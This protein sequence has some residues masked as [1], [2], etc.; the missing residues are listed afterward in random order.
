[1][2]RR[3]FTLLEILLSL[4]I[5]A[6]VLVALNALLFGVAGGWGEGRDRRL[7]DQH[8][9]ALG[10]QLEE[11]VRAAAERPGGA[12][13]AI[14]KQAWAGRGEEL[15]PG[16]SLPDGGRLATWAGE[17]LPD[18][19]FLLEV[20]EDE[21]LVVAWRSRAEVEMESDGWH[22]AVVSPFVRR[23][24]YAYAPAGEG[25]RWEVSETPLPEPGFTGW[26]TP[27]HLRLHLEMGREKAEVRVRVLGKREGATPP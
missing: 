24:E 18:V 4:A 2:R 16:W 11:S 20:D 27:D 1:M 12:P 14:R 9:R 13:L 26:R 19:D 15:R 21:G 17:P 25:G 10:R 22:E 6:G 8:R 3:G 23:L 7:F 5:L